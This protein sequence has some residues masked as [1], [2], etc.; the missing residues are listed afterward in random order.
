MSSIDSSSS[1]MDAV[2]FQRL[3][4]KAYLERFLAEGVRPDGRNPD[5]W[6]DLKVNVGS[7]STADGSAL[8]RLG[9]TTVVCGVK[10]E[11]A[12]PDL[13]RPN[14]GFIVPNVDLPALCSPRFKSGPPG[15]EAQIISERLNDM[16]IASKILSTSSLC[17][18]PGKFV[19]VLYI[20]VACINYDGNAFDA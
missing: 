15:E 10:L 3:H 4:P 9:N 11:I 7:I 14:D 2:I 1:N 6:R 16:I 12:E 13:S 8:V 17:I 5:V 20:D 19:W 18:H